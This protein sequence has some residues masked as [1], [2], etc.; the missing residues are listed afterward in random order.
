LGSEFAD[1]AAFHNDLAAKYDSHLAISEYNSLAREAFVELV[2]RHVAPGST[3]LDF[4]CGTG[5]DACHY[6]RKG[7]RVQAYD[8]SPGMIAQLEQRCKTEIASGDIIAW[9]EGYPSFLARFPQLPAPSAVVANFAVL[10]SIP[11]LETLFDTLRRHLSPPGWVIVSLLNPLHWQKL[12]TPRWWLKGLWEGHR[13]PVFTTQPFV[14][15]L[16]FVPGLL[17]AAQGFHLVGRA[18][19]GR[20]V[21]YDAVMPG[22]EATFWWGQADSRRKRLERVLWQTPA[23]LFL[24]HF[25]F[26]VLRRDL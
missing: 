12:K 24:G 11:N 5:I 9:S 7:Y 14:T 8:N 1:N 2:T 19:S 17:R 16:H 4:G 23:R 18:N 26:L 25:V 6:A 13:S 20:F 22:D 15:S 21:R 3:L 10:N